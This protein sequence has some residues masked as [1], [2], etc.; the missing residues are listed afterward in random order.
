M[1]M[2]T[3]LDLPELLGVCVLALVLFLAIDLIWLGVIAKDFYRR[4]LKTLMRPDPYKPAAVLFYLLFVIGLVYFAIAPALRSESLTLAM[5]SGALYGFFTYMTYEL[6]N[7]AVIKKWP[8]KLVAAD[9]VW[10]TFLAFSI[11]TITFSIFWGIL[12]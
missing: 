2:A 4:H 5:S 8:A 6:T 9:I 12:S 10:G 7:W 11:S 1:T 3:Q